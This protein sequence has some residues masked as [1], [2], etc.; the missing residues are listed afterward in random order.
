[1]L[2]SPEPSIDEL[3]TDPL[4][5]ALMAA[6]GVDPDELRALLYSAAERVRA[7]A[8]KPDSSPPK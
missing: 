2:E 6:D 5:R 1:M 7:C 3:L 4:I 8:I